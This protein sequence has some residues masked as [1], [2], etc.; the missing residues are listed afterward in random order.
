MLKMSKLEVS[1]LVWTQTMTMND[2]PSHSG[3]F[4]VVTAASDNVS[5]KVKCHSLTS[6]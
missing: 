3:H 6:C 4:K 2:L 5:R 1:W